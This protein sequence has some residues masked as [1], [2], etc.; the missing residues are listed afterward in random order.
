MARPRKQR[1]AANRLVKQL[2]KIDDTKLVHMNEV[3]EQINSQ[4]GGASRFAQY[5]NEGLQAAPPGSLQQF[6]FL[7]CWST[8]IREYSR[9]LDQAQREESLMTDEQMEEELQ[10]RLRAIYGDSEAAA[11]NAVEPESEIVL[12]EEETGA[13]AVPRDTAAPE[14][15]S[16]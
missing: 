1:D 7:Q 8:F 13:D 5:L 2:A 11:T 10:R 9:G 15:E 3:L 16:A 12:S 14:S 4:C 6:R